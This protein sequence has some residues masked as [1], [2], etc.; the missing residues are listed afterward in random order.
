MAPSTSSFSRCVTC[1]A[2]SADSGSASV[3]QIGA[4]IAGTLA[5]LVAAIEQSVPYPR[6][7]PL[8]SPRNTASGRSPA[9]AS[10]LEPLLQLVERLDELRYAFALKLAPRRPP[11]RP[12]SR[13]SPLARIAA[14]GQWRSRRSFRPAQAPI[15][16]SVSSGMVLTVSGTTSSSN[17]LGRTV[18]WILVEV[19]PIAA[20]E[21]AH[22]AT[23][24][25]CH[26]GVAIIS[27]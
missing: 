5:Q 18:A 8:R 1:S 2:K 15:G 13:S 14:L 10:L 16:L 24:N 17:I 7:H 9:A 6:W 19:T 26:C 12:S 23:A 20:V 11:D 22:R 3:A 21:A 4:R 25:S 27:W